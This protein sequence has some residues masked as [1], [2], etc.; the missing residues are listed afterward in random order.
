MG[1]GHRTQAQG[2]GG[3]H[4]I[5]RVDWLGVGSQARKLGTSGAVILNFPGAVWPRPVVKG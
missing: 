3:Q 4:E 2:L 1:Q 5:V